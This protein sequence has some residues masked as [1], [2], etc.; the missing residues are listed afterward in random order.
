M[1]HRYFL[2]FSAQNPGWLRRVGA[3]GVTALLAAC[4]TPSMTAQGD[5]SLVAQGMQIFR[6]DTFG[7]EAQWTDP[8]KLHQVIATAVDPT[9]ALSVGLKVDA[10][11]LPL[12]PAGSFDAAAAQREKVLCEGGTTQL[13]GA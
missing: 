11:A 2:P 3:M 12:P 9:T 4:G 6:F 13:R 1:P 5:P 10:Q 8:L 7:N